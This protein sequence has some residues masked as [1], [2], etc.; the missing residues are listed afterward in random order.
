MPILVDDV[1]KAREQLDEA[2]RAAGA[3]V[4]RVES[5]EDTP[6]IL[7]ACPG[8]DELRELMCALRPGLVY[9]STAT[10]STD[11]AEAIL[12][13]S[14]GELPAADV[15]ARDFREGMRRAARLTMDGSGYM[16]RAGFVHAGFM[17]EALIADRV[18]FPVM[19]HVSG[20]VRSIHD[21]DEEVLDEETDGDELVT[22]EPA[23][24]ARLI[25]DRL[26]VDGFK[27]PQLKREAL[28]LVNMAVAD[29][30]GDVADMTPDA[31]RRIE[32][33][34]RLAIRE[35]RRS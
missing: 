28:P 33:A 15:D 16:F 12:S 24:G 31:K 25:V 26:K 29:M 13:L 2:A 32:E 19:D 7:L 30:V 17:H 1:A 22:A 5:M 23:E 8:L 20:I 9:V 11:W 27:R 6:S 10:G 4:V 21:D 35:L 18:A 14:D 34:K 3:R